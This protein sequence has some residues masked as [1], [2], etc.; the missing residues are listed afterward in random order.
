M[1]ER[2]L[3]HHMC[4]RYF[5]LESWKTWNAIGIGWQRTTTHSSLRF[6]R[7]V[8]QITRNDPA[9]CHSTTRWLGEV[10]VSLCLCKSLDFKPY[11]QVQTFNSSHPPAL[12][13]KRQHPNLPAVRTILS[14]PPCCRN[15]SIILQLHSVT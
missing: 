12:C 3:L 5:L 4:I 14:F 9:H 8:W 1:E 10:R 11:C 15:K 2:L 7:L 13:C 6:N